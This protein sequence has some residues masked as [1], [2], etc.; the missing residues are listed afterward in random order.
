[1]EKTTTLENKAE[2]SLQKAVEELRAIAKRE[3]KTGTAILFVG[4]NQGGATSV[5]V[6]MIDWKSTK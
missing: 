6:G 5:K 3:R 1:M 4:L 2:D